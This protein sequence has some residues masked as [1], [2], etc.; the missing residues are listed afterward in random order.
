MTD[1][2]VILYLYPNNGLGYESAIKVISLPQ[3]ERRSVRPPGRCSNA[4]EQCETPSRQ[5]RESTEQTEELEDFENCPYIALRFSDGA[6][7]R[8]GIVTGCADDVDLA[9]L[10]GRGISRH[11]LAFTSDDQN[12]PIARDLGSSCGTGVVYNGVSSNRRSNFDWLLQ[13]PSILRDKFLVLDIAGSIQFRVS[14]PYV[15]SRR[16]TTSTG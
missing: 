10:K 1:P 12:R 9:L 15:I 3:N 13:G 11:H 2:D 14:F 4:E 5:D 8:L 16:R 7:S 6:R